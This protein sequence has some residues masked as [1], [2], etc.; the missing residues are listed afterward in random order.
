MIL[1][2]LH[3]RPWIRQEQPRHR[4]YKVA[5]GVVVAR[6]MATLKTMQRLSA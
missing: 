5:A 4:T 3:L 1:A 6:V 2:A